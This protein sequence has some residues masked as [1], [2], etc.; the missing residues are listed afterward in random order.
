ME[1]YEKIPAFDIKSSLE[2]IG[3]GN[4]QKVELSEEYFVWAE[5]N[6]E[7]EVCTALKENYTSLDV[8]KYTYLSDGLNI[9]G[10]LWT[11][12]HIEHPLPLIVWNR[13]G[14]GEYGSTGERTG[15]AYSNIA[16]D[17]AKYGAVVVGSEYRGGVGSEGKDEWG[18]ADVT[19]V[20]TLKKIADTLP[21]VSSPDALIAGESRGGM[22]SYQLASKEEWVKGIISLSGT[23]DLVAS[24]AE[25]PIMNDVFNKA[26]GGS[27][28]EMQKRSAVYFYNEIPKD[29]PILILHGAKDER[30]SIEQ[31]RVLHTHLEESGHAVEYHEFLE[32]DH[33]FYNHSSP[34]RKEVESILEH[35]VREH[36]R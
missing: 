12:K 36:T 24:A 17:L 10:F 29:T 28:E 23:T 9:A 30:V 21:F 19:D 27:T 31:V 22:M 6:L 34:Y 5:N 16:C 13:G 25:D 4:V 3:L 26:F 15:I 14:T 7:P 11:P 35:F 8:H 18:G 1:S 33:G 2:K 20:V 32:G